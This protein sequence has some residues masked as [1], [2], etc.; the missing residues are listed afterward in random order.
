MVL[1]F[2]WFMMVEMVGMVV[3]ELDGIVVLMLCLVNVF[4][5][6]FVVYVGVFEGVGWVVVFVEM[7]DVFE[8]VEGIFVVVIDVGYGGIDFGV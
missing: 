5:D 2:V 8:S 6:E 4:D 1:E 3:N 7:F